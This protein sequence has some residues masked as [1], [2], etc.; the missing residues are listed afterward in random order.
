[1]KNKFIELYL[2]ICRLC[3]T[4]AV[5]KHQRLSPSEVIRLFARVSLLVLRKNSAWAQVPE[6]YAQVTTSG[7]LLR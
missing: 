7:I 5:L 2:L 3:D 4:E 6:E 1:V